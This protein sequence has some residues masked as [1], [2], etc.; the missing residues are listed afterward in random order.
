MI[1]L[2]ASISLKKAVM[3]AMG[4]LILSLFTLTSCS[5]D[6]SADQDAGSGTMT[7]TINGQNWEGVEVQAIYENGVFTIAGSDV[8]PGNT[9]QINISGM[10]SSEGT[11]QIRLIGG[12]MGIYTSATS[13]TDVNP[14]LGT[15]GELVIEEL[16]NG[17][18]SGS[19]QFSGQGFNVTEG[20]FS[21]SF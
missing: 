18:T 10:L 9:Q 21:I 1:T 8:V 4:L 11:Y 2:N 3:I 16:S 14:N 5:D 17:R 12:I 6:N 13:P 7:A 19:F 20:E 15:T